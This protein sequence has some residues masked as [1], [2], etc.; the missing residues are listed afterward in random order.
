MSIFSRGHREEGGINRQ[1]REE[2]KNTHLFFK[3][4]LC[5]QKVKRVQ[6]FPKTP[7][8]TH[9]Q[10]SELCTSPADWDICYH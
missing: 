8:T 10:P 5:S 6:A 2:L 3:A 7:R 1:S 4:F 9:A